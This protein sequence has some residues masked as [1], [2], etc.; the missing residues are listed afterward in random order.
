MCGSQFSKKRDNGLMLL[1]TERN[2]NDIHLLRKLL[3]ADFSCQISLYISSQC[4]VCER[5]HWFLNSAS[6]RS[7]N[8]AH[9]IEFFPILS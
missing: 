5:W 7:E 6:N 3:S 4:L 8:L 2:D 1:R 9:I